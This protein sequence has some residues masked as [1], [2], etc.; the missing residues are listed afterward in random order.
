[1]DPSSSAGAI[2]DA[3][4]ELFGRDGYEGMSV[5]AI[6]ARA[7][8]C[9]ATVFHHFG[10]KEG[11]YIAVMEEIS[12]EFAGVARPLLEGP[13][14]C[15]DKLRALLR[16]DFELAARSEVR[17]RLVMR[18]LEDHCEHAQRLAQQVFHDNFTAVLA[19]FES[20]RASGEF[21]ADIDPAMATLTLMAARNL[22]LRSLSLLRL[23]AETRHLEDADTYI[24][25]LCD[26]MLKGLVAAAA[27]ACADAPRH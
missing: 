19:L 24:E 17:S 13:G 15:A 14:S 1:M 4:T 10:S 18:A 11:L 5:A 23:S 3:A 16:L 27:P 22:F 25:R 9:K 20:G 8:V 26:L 2:I 12:R 21:R 7:G 6:A